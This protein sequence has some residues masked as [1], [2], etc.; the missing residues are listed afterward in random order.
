MSVNDDNPPEDGPAEAPTEEAYIEVQPTGVK[1]RARG[2][3]AAEVLVRALLPTLL[4]GA[5]V[6]VPTAFVLANKPLWLAAVALVLCWGAALTLRVT[7]ARSRRNPPPPR[8]RS[9]PRRNR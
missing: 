1:M 7:R 4:V 8:R 9:S 6:V 3:A 2:P 5:G